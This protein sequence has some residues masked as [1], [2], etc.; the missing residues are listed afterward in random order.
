MSASTSAPSASGFVPGARQPRCRRQS[1]SD[2]GAPALKGS[3][4]RASCP[5]SWPYT[6][7][8][9]LRRSRCPDLHMGLRLPACSASCPCGYWH[10][11]DSN[12]GILPTKNHQYNAGGLLASSETRRH[13]T[14]P[15]SCK[16]SWRKRMELRHTTTIEAVLEH[17]IAN[18]ATDLGRVFGQL[19]ELAMQIERE[20][21]LKAGHRT[22]ER[23][24]Q[25]LQADRHP[26]C[27][28]SGAKR[29]R[30]RPVPSRLNAASDLL[31]P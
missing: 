24:G 3:P 8:L 17:L 25:R 9:S 19:F 12:T 16:H 18:G 6:L 20:Q 27:Y 4:G 11:P 2:P 23:Q 26:H 22:P 31:A 10:C 15:W 30:R 29:S 1:P 14:I 7:L 21:H 5:E 28:H 13:R